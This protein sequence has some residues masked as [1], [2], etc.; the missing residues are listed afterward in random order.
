MGSFHN[1]YTTAGVPQ[2][3]VL[4]PLVILIVINNNAST[5]GSDIRL[6]ADDS[7]LFVIHP[8]GVDIS[9]LP[10]IDSFNGQNVGLLDLIH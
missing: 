10:W 6:F 7:S 4:G 9:H 2:G 1:G 5:L 3:S 8:P